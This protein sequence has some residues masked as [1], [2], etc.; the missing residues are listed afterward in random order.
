MSGQQVMQLNGCTLPPAAVA[1]VRYHSCYSIHR[2][3]WRSPP[4][5][6]RPQPPRRT[7]SCPAQVTDVDCRREHAYGHLL[8]EGDEELM[9]WVREFKCA[10]ASLTAPHRKP[11]LLSIR[12]LLRPAQGYPLPY[13]CRAALLSSTILLRQQARPLLEVD[14]DVRRGGA[15]AVLPVADFEILS[16]EAPMVKLRR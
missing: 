1:I 4:L 7:S 12:S 8:K 16:G 14:R 2:R 9:R 5:S 13:R 6:S 11:S 3:A 10:R 15:E